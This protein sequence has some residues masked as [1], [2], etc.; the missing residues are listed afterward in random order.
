MVAAAIPKT[1]VMTILATLFF[2]SSL[3]A[4]NNRKC[5]ELIDISG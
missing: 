3:L 2:I 5:M 1:I 4:M